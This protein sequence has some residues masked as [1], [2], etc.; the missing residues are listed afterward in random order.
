M[1]VE[2]KYHNEYQKEYLRPL[3]HEAFA[4]MKKRTK[5]P[6]LY[7]Y[8][9]FGWGA[10]TLSPPCVRYPMHT[11]V[12]TNRCHSPVHQEPPIFCSNVQL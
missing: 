9:E 2:R 3:L 5:S 12:A 8:D 7:V 11:Y 4:L 10:N 1:R 6:S